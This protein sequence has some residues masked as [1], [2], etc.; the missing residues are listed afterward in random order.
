MKIVFENNFVVKEKINLT[1]SLLV[2]LSFLLFHSCKKEESHPIFRMSE[3]DQTITQFAPNPSD[4]VRYPKI[5]SYTS[6]IS[7]DTNGKLKRTTGLWGGN[8][9]RYMYHTPINNYQI[10]YN[11][12][13][14][15]LGSIQYI[16]YSNPLCCGL[17]MKEEGRGYIFLNEQGY[18]SKI[19]HSGI[20][21]DWTTVTTFEYTPNGFIKKIFC[22]NVYYDNAELQS[23]DIEGDKVVSMTDRRTSTLIKYVF[24]YYDEKVGI[25]PVNL[26]LDFMGKVSPFLIKKVS[27]FYDAK[28][29][30][31]DEYTYETD[32]RN[33][34]TKAYCTSYRAS[35]GSKST[36]IETIYH[37]IEIENLN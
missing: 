32:Y 11:Y 22:N 4:T 5:S 24:E 8:I 21:E 15:S 12:S 30:L 20:Y 3:I 27:T 28:L 33:L 35:N 1:L 9:L 31:T 25:N 14:D 18:I 37:Y 34:V 2:L 7:W 29:V 19:L 26:G 6:N 13:P 10:E 16:E 17:K 23:F 36:S